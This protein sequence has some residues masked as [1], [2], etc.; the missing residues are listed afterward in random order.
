M[1]WNLFIDDIRNLPYSDI[2]NRD[3]F[4]TYFENS[5]VLARNFEEVKSLIAANGPPQMISFDHDL[6]LLSYAN[7]ADP[8]TEITGL[9][10]A[11]WLCEKDFV[12]NFTFFPKDFCYYSHSSNPI[13]KQRIMDYMEFYFEKIREPV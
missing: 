4:G 13:G 2:Y 7:A 11:K 6:G 5:W 10:I 9:T 8:A 3:S 12:S 1:I